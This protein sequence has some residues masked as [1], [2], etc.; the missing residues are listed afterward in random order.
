MVQEYHTKEEIAELAAH[1]AAT[2]VL[3]TVCFVY[4]CRRLIDLSLIAGGRPQRPVSG[5]FSME[6]SR[7]PMEES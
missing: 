5:Q 4:T 7:F 2:Y 3:D 6:E 1:H